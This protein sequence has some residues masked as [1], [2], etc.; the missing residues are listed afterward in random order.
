M[1]GSGLVQGSERQ[2]YERY[3]HVEWMVINQQWKDMH[4][5]Y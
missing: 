5:I 4:V 3:E 1:Y 2:W